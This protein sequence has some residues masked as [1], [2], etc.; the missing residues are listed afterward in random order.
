MRNRF[1]VM[2]S[3][4]AVA[5]TAAGQARNPSAKSYSP[6]RMPDGHPNLQG[7]YDL[8]TLTPLERPAGMK[9][10]LTREEAAGIEQAIAARQEA[11]GQ[12]IQGDRQAPPKGGDGSTGPAGGVGGYNNFWLD[13]GSSYTIVNGEIR[14][15]LIVDPPDGRV[16]P[17]IRSA[18]QRNAARVV[19][20]TSDTT[21][22]RDPGLEPPG[23]YDNPEQ[24]P[25]GERCLLGFGSTSGPPALPDYFYNNLHQIVQTPDY[26]MILTEMVHDARIVRMNAQH[27]PKTVRKWMGDSVGRWEGD[28]LVIDTTNFSD[29]TRFRGASEDLHVTERFTRVAGNALLYRFTIEDPATWERPWTGEFMWPATDKPI[30]EYACHESNYALEN[31]L[32]GARRREADEAARKGKE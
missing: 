18:Q 25:L 10:A 6:P 28:S 17:M 30:Y 22:S 20:A 23:S 11:A 26:V 9:A 32:R 24:R 1:F 8:A 21:E 29:K 12:P 2:L 27:L 7:T 31:I 4:M 3:M 13:P 5:I 19:A 15:S 14:T 16:P